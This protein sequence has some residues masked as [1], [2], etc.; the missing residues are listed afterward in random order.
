MPLRP[1]FLEALALFAKATERLAS[2]GLSAPVLVGGA[3]VELYTGGFIVSGDFDF[4]SDWQSEFFGELRTLGFE[5]PTQVG[6]LQRSLLHPK[7]NIAVQIVSGSLMDGHTDI[8][9]VQILDL[10]TPDTDKP[11]TLKVIPIEDLIADRMAQAL[12]GPRIEITM[13]NQAIRLYQF[14]EGLDEDYLDSRIKEETGN[15]A[16]FET[17]R[18]WIDHADNHASRT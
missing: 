17:L 15:E 14:A 5:R 18:S 11:L 13:R 6:W 16:S 2:R 1:E 7:L 10:G 3:A 12:S 9:R 4:V 8:N